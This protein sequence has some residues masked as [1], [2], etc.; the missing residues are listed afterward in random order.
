MSV[1]V[2]LDLQVKPENRDELINTLEA[3]L[4]DTRAYQGCQNIKVTS[5]QDEPNN[6]V[7]LE[8]WDNRS[9]HESYMNWRA[10][11]GD[12]EKLGALLSEPPAVRYLDPISV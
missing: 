1:N 9:D 5:N 7:I 4:P 10:E 12:L 11:R 3:I 6:I 8:K 2:V